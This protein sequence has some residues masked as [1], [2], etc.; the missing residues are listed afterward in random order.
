[1]LFIDLAGHVVDL[2][3]SLPAGAGEPAHVHDRHVRHHHHQR[4]RHHGL[5]AGHYRD[6]A[7][8]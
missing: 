6:A 3:A 8:I 1:M 7:N 2:G 5:P 4:A